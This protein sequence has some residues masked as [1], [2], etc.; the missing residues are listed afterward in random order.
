MEA[1]AGEYVKNHLHLKRFPHISLHCKL[2]PVQYWEYKYDLLPAIFI[3]DYRSCNRIIVFTWQII[4]L[5]LI[6]ALYFS[7]WRGVFKYCYIDRKLVRSTSMG[8]Y[9]RWL[10]PEFGTTLLHIMVPILSIWY[11]QSLTLQLCNEFRLFWIGVT[12][13]DM[14]SLL[15]R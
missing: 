10:I 7:R 1:N 12:R 15:R 9:G 3:P 2:V 6:L 5:S 8:S 13:C 11:P 14:V 4:L